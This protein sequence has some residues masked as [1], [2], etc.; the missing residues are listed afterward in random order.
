MRSSS[1]L[2]YTRRSSFS[3][4]SPPNF[5]SEI[6]FRAMGAA[7]LSHV[8]RLPSGRVW[9]RLAQKQSASLKKIILEDHL[10]AASL[11]AACLWAVFLAVASPAA[12]LLLALVVHRHPVRPVAAGQIRRDV[13]FRDGRSSK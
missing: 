9:P 12:L 10:E 5:H 2:V 3:G 8:R 7:S 6:L 1:I 4:L 11:L 13:P